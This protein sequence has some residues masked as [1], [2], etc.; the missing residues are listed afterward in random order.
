MV[1]LGSLIS[2]PIYDS[3]DR[4]KFSKIDNQME[5]ILASIEA[6]NSEKWS[7]EKKC[8]EIASGPWPTGEY[9]CEIEISTETTAESASYASSLH[10]TYYPI[11]NGSEQ[12][13]DNGN[14]DNQPS[15]SFGQKFIVSS[16]EKNYTTVG[17]NAPCHYLSKLI[18]QKPEQPNYRY[19]DPINGFG[20]VRTSLSCGDKARSNWY[21]VN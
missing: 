19:G 12:L 4:K 14:L 7:Y 15:N 9:W 3:L 5:E 17:T 13:D 1:I 18:P 10:N 21:D 11:L 2:P 6:A 20:T 8:D 16:V